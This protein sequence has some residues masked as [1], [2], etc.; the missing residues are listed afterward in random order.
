[1]SQVFDEVTPPKLPKG[2]TVV[3]GE[4]KL[5]PDLAKTVRDHHEELRRTFKGNPQQWANR[6]ELNQVA[7]KLWLKSL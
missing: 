3:D 7:A 6:L 4:L 5:R 2:V 1:M